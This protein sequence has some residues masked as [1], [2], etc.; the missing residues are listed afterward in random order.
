MDRRVQVSVHA[1][2]RDRDGAIIGYGE[3]VPGEIE[4]AGTLAG[5][6]NTQV[7]NVAD[8]NVYARPAGPAP[9]PG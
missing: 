9:P 4:P 6:V 2:F 7:P 1:I 3:D 5:Q 8:V